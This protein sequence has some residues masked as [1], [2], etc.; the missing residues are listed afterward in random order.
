MEIYI[1]IRT[2][3]FSVHCLLLL[4]CSPSPAQEAKENNEEQKQKDKPASGAPKDASDQTTEDKPA[5]AKQEDQVEQPPAAATT[6]TATEDRSALAKVDN[7][8]KKKDEETELRNKYP[9]ST[10][11]YAVLVK[12]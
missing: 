8:Q 10:L 6:S 7:G 1:C 2:L 3:N 5:A 11:S 9:T 12:R 4:A